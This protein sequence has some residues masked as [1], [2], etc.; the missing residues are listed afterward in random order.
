MISQCGIQP[1]EDKVQAIHDAPAPCDINQVKSV[2]VSWTLMSSLFLICW[3][4]LHSS[5]LFYK[6]RLAGIGVCCNKWHLPTPTNSY[7]QMAFWFTT[8][9]RNHLLCLWML[10]HMVSDQPCLIHF[11]MAMRSP[12]CVPP[13]QL[14]QQSMGSMGTLKLT[15]KVLPLFWCHKV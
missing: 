7:H 9:I 11:Q 12:L 14:P 3:P 8:V 15:R 1:M 2:L 5:I 13:V 4:N 10:H 6:R